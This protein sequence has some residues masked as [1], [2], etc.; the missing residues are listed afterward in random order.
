M[1]HTIPTK[2]R[3]I[4]LISGILVIP[5]AI[6]RF[7]LEEPDPFFAIIWTV[8]GS[9]FI[10]ISGYVY[11]YRKLIIEKNNVT[12]K[13]INYTR[14]RTIDKSDIKRVWENKTHFIIDLSDEVIE[15]EKEIF[16]KPEQVAQALSEIKK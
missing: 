4:Y 16:N 7:F 1:K 3:P 6:S 9:I 8:Y 15:I 12:L 5:L 11:A 13:N 10:L 2:R 14:K